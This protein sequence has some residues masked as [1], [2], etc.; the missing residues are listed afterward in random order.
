M[1]P[2]SSIHYFKTEG[3]IVE[4]DETIEE[5]DEISLYKATNASLLVKEML[6]KKRHKRNCSKYFKLN[7]KILR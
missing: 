1:I 7:V 6:N 3:T 4:L 2:I 5:L